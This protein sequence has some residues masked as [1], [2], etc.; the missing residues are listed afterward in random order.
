MSE[1]KRPESVLVVVYTRNGQVL[2]LERNDW[3]DFWQSVTGSL[4]SDEIPLMSAER[5]LTEETGLT[6]LQGDLHDCGE[7]QWFDIYPQFQHR[8]APGVTQ[9]LEHVFCF[10]L[11]KPIEITL[12]KEHKSYCWVTKE[13]ALANMTSSTNHQAIQKYV[14]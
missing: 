8:Y 13:K 12:S 9:N 14:P 3:P 11:E 2:L 5:E 6:P 7:S 1:F 10:V 4:N